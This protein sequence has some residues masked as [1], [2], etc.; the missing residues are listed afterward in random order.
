MI[1]CDWGNCFITAKFSKVNIVEKL[2]FNHTK[3]PALWSFGGLKILVD[4]NI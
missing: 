4:L 1:F 2:N 3:S